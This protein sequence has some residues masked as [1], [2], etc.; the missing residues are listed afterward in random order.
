M[1]TLFWI[2]V[3][4]LV[5]FW[6]YKNRKT[7]KGWFKKSTADKPAAGDSTASS[8]APTSTSGTTTPPSNAP[9]AP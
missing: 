7:V 5:G 9:P 3:F 1:S 4:A 8:G 2:A 6:A